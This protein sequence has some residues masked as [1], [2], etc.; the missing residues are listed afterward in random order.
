[1]GSVM[2]YGEQGQDQF[3]GMHSIKEVLIVTAPSGNSVST[4]SAP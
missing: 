4:L 2:G 3:H 1:M